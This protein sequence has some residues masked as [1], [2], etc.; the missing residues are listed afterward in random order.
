[1]AASS[2]HIPWILGLDLGTSTLGWAVIDVDADA[3]E[4]VIPI[5][6]RDIGVSRE[7]GGL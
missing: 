3:A 1:M 6:V 2:N 4:N 5:A 7:T